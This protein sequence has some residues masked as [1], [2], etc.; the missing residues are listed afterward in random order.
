LVLPRKKVVRSQ[1]FISKL[2][3]IGINRRS[4]DVIMGS[5]PLD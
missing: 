4:C 1:R 3:F 2:I 5:L